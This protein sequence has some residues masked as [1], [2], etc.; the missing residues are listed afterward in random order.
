MA[1]VPA[2][3]QPDA[4]AAPAKPAAPAAPAVPAARAPV[5]PA[6]VP[7]APKPQ[8]RAASVLDEPDPGAPDP[9]AAPAAPIQMWPEDWREQIA[10]NDPKYLKALSR[11]ASVKDVANALVAAQNR[12][13]SGELLPALKE[14]AT[15]DELASWRTEAGIPLEATAYP[16]PDG[17]VFG[18]DDKALVESFKK[19]AL[20]ANYRPDQ[21]KAALAWFHGDREAQLE[22]LVAEDDKHRIET[23]EAMTATW[24]KDKERNKSMVNGLLDEA[25]PA[26]AERI[27]GARG[28]DDRALLNDFGVLEWLHSLAFKINPVST[29][30]PGTTGD[31]GAAID[32]EIAKWEGQ[33]GDT[34]S[35]YWGGKQGNKVMAEKNQSRLRELYAARDRYKQKK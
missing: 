6:A 31:V 29:V 2:A 19:A 13:R 30:V 7:A 21:V 33:M 8:P 5:A 32:D 35:D 3:R 9:A 22:A 15:P 23:V 18:E 20:E 27:R 25:P 12:I 16:D 1:T 26:I 14:N 10:G 4:P 11:Y 28:P 24:G 17:I 34:K